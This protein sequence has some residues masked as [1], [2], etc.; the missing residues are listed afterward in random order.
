MSIKGIVVKKDLWPM[1]RAQVSLANGS[2]VAVG[3]PSGESKTD[4]AHN[5]GM[6]NVQV[7]IANELGS[8]PGVTP[9]VHPRPFMRETFYRKKQDFLKVQ[10]QLMAMILDAQMSTKIALERIGRQGQSEVQK[11][12]STPGTIAYEPGWEPVGFK[13]DN[14]PFTIAKK[15]SSIPLIDTGA[16]RQAV[17]WKV[18]MRSGRGMGKKT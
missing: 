8:G 6:S 12:M 3:F 4:A 10:R 13:M 11:T 18:F 14:S 2:F 7:A 15:E 5:P 16:L 17:T 9:P 1:I